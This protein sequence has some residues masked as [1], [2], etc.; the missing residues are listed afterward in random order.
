MTLTPT[1]AAPQA[2]AAQ[3]LSFQFVNYGADAKGDLNVIYITSDAGYNKLQWKILLNTGSVELLPAPSI[4]D[5]STLGPD[6]QQGSLLYLS[7]QPL[8]L[9][10][11]AFGALS[12]S[13][14]DWTFKAFPDQ[15]TIGMTPTRPITL[16]STGGAAQSITVN[17]LELVTATQATANLDTQIYDSH[18]LNVYGNFKVALQQPPDSHSGNLQQYLQVQL[19]TNQILNSFGVTPAVANTLQLVL[20]PGQQS[21]SIAA[22]AGSAFNVSFVYGVPGDQEGYGALTTNDEA[23]RIAVTRLT[24][25]DHWQIVPNPSAQNVSWDLLPPSG[26]PIVGSGGAT[27]VGFQFAGIETDY[28]P[29]PT[30]MLVAYKNIP[31]YQD[32]VYTIVLDKV[33]HVVIGDLQVTPDPAVAGEGGQAQV[34]VSWT[35]NSYVTDLVLTQNSVPYMVTGTTSFAAT[36]EAETTFFTLAASGPLAELGNQASL[37]ATA[38]ALP[39]IDSFIATPTHIHY[40]GGSHQASLSWAVQSAADG[41]VS[42][43]STSASFAP[44]TG[45]GNAETVPVSLAGPQMITLAPDGDGTPPALTRSIVVSA[46][47]P[48]ASQL[49]PGGAPSGVAASPGAPFVAVSDSAGSRVLI[50]DT[51]HF[52]MQSTV[53]VGSQP[54]PIAFSA[55]GTLMLV[56]NLGD[57]SLT[58]VRVSIQGGAPVFEAQSPIALS[59]GTP[60]SVLVRPDGKAAWVVVDG[61]AGPGVLYALADAGKGLAVTSRV[62]LGSAP[63]GLAALPSGAGLYVA[64]AGDGSVSVIS[65]AVN[66]ALLSGTPI[67]NVGRQPT[68]VAMAGGGRILLVSCAGD[69]TVVAVD[70]AHPLG[71]QRV[72]V[73]VGQQPGAVAVTPGG[74]YAWVANQGGGTL[75]LLDC[76]GSV[77]AVK[78]VGDPIPAGPAP[79]AVTVTPDGLNV[80][81]ADGGGVTLVTLNTYAAQQNA[82][83]LGDHMTNVAVAPDNSTVLVWQNPLL[84]VAST[85][86]L[87]AYT[88]GTGAHD[89]VLGANQVI[90]CVFNPNPAQHAAYAL[91]GEGNQIS[92]IST[93]D[94]GVTPVPLTLPSSDCRALALGIGGDD[95]RLFVAYVD[96]ANTIWLA[97]LASGGGGWSTAQ[98][99]KLYQA[100]ARPY[101][102]LLAVTRDNQ[103]IVIVDPQSQ[104]IRFAHAV[105]GTYV[106]D[107]AT[108]PARASAVGIALLP[109]GSKAYVLNSGGMEDDI[110]VIDLASLTSTV[111]NIPQPYVSLTGIA[112]APDGSVLYASDA[113]SAALRLLDPASLRILQTIALAGAG[114]HPVQDAVAVAAAP[115]A[116]ALYVV[117]NASN[118]LSVIQQIQMQ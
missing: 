16:E 44:L 4:P 31:G 85:D 112:S 87:I 72:P 110:T 107:G 97:V 76:G 113:D 37:N 20:A 95:S 80:L 25:A 88:P 13:A 41:K 60:Q 30:A 43:S 47:Q 33:G 79:V 27:T 94:L 10:S 91:L 34:T 58:P 106:A 21:A 109:D 74:S 63:R 42:V 78:V 7:L 22:G 93:P 54:G 15:Q 56:A 117:N 51:V 36:L 50:L 52:Q 73:A 104:S 9:S 75:S 8:G 29:G 118:N 103:R 17:T 86:G 62:S 68:G 114:G 11:A 53:A 45:L 3:Q 90:S 14:A 28:Q 12:F 57:G 81:S 84:G 71:G 67:P 49:Q 96:K 69:N 35:A 77:G 46:F 2:D 19:N 99:L 39:A 100:S 18:F 38:T 101:V 116:S 59:G 89:A 111:V 105:G 98:T 108:V 66:G 23:T 82:V 48:A 70:A 65:I 6:G 1:Q 26:Q 64:N 102:L 5:P 61:G 92:Q 32:G 55:D 115:D 24:G 83:S 40:Q